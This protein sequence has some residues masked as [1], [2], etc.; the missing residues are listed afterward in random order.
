M[1][2]RCRRGQ[3]ERG[4]RRD[5]GVSSLRKGFS[6][7]KNG[8][9][10]TCTGRPQL[11]NTTPFAARSC[12]IYRNL[13]LL[14]S[15]RMRAPEHAIPAP[16]FPGKLTWVNVAPLR[17]DKQRGR[18]VLVE[19]WD[20]CRVNSLRTLPYLKAWHERYAA[21]G[22]RVIGMHT[23]GFLPARD[24]GE[25]RAAVERLGIEY[26]VVIDS[27]S[28]S[29]TSTA[30]RAG[31]R[32]TCG[33]RRARSTRCTTARAPTGD[34]ARDPGAARRRAR[35]VPPLR[36]EDAPD[37]C[38]PAQTEDQP[39][40]YSG[41][42]EAAARGRCW[43]GRRGARERPHARRRAAGLPPARGAPAPHG[44]ACSISRSARGV[45]LRHVLHAGGRQ[46]RRA[47]VAQQADEPRRAVVLEEDGR[48][49]PV[50]RRVGLREEVRLVDPRARVEDPARR[51]R[52]PL[53]RVVARPR[54][55]SGGCGRRSRAAR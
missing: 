18:P 17:M 50:R 3:C 49:R 41:P 12:A 1:T 53:A 2:G 37:G 36:P 31:R 33:T 47:S 43:R 21:D 6:S 9:R 52:D 51:R 38:S 20:F 55:R 24:D 15:T 4:G 14:A 10:T 27:G 28:R 42:Y 40:A 35:A 32:A 30:T 48:A 25:G 39:G 44:G 45:M 46:L 26:P 34:G 13:S 23:G 19:F 5:R 54:A 7:S 11:A 22:L 16:P 8:Q 29:G